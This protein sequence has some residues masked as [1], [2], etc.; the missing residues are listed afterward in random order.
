MFQ[1][2]AVTTFQYVKETKI[3]SV[4]TVSDKIQN[5]IIETP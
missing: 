4:Q 5:F 3:H 1:K 2:I